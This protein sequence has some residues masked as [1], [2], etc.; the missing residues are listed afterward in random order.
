MN[1]KGCVVEHILGCGKG[2][3]A[4][5]CFKPGSNVLEVFGYLRN[6]EQKAN[7]FCVMC[8]FFKEGRKCDDCIAVHEETLFV[9]FELEGLWYTMNQ[10]SG[11]EK[12]PN[13]DI[14]L[15]YMGC[16]VACIQ[17]VA[18]KN[19]ILEGDEIRW[20]YGYIPPNAKKT[21][22]VWSQIYINREIHVCSLSPAFYINIE[23]LDCDICAYN[24]HKDILHVY[25]Y[26]SDELVDILKALS[27]PEGYHQSKFHTSTTGKVFQVT[28]TNEKMSCGIITLLQNEEFNEMKKQYNIDVRQKDNPTTPE[29]VA[30]QWALDHI[31]KGNDLIHTSCGHDSKRRKQSKLELEQ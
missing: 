29:N 8:A 1:A 17:F 23:D 31:Q 21:Q 4:S 24:L 9:P 3:M 19:G 12:G 16:G 20:G 26:E 25:D 5:E 10:A 13:V 15:I 11:K 7:A 14:K 27:K 28:T 22:D 18:K 2:L 30:M 6:I